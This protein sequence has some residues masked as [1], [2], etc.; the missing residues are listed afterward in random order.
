MLGTIVFILTFSLSTTALLMEI[1][2]LKSRCCFA[3]V[4]AF[5]V[6]TNG[7]DWLLN[8]LLAI[9]SGDY[10]IRNQVLCMS[11]RCRERQMDREPAKSCQAQQGE[12]RERDAVE[13]NERWSLCL[14]VSL[15]L[16]SPCCL[17]PVRVHYNRSLCEL[18]PSVLCV[19][20][21][22]NS[23]QLSK[24]IILLREAIL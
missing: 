7:C 6:V 5:S 14:C 8:S 18:H 16:I 13:E 21:L 9:T 22:K 4:A 23:Q 3:G 15:L 24:Q 17:F 20:V 12:G 1:I 11:L 19:S 10:G 2:G